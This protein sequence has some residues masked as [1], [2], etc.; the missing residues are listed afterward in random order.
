M[1][2][3]FK[4]LQDLFAANLN[5]V[6]N[7]EDNPDAVLGQAIG[8]LQES[9]AA[10]RDAVID[11][12]TSEKQLHR[13]LETQRRQAQRWQERASRALNSENEILARE[14]LARKRDFDAIVQALAQSH[15][16]AQQTTAR[17]KSRLAALEQKLTETREAQHQLR[18][19]PRADAG[20]SAGDG[21]EFLG[22]MGARLAK[23]SANLKGGNSAADEDLARNFQSIEEEAR[24]ESELA[25][26]KRNL[27][28]D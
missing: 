5:E 4:R 8:E 3:L 10:S 27:G 11:A 26:L 19:E 12:L 25:D 23:L 13:E 15:Q 16:L 7:R 28:K 20:D 2:R 14:A 6:L 9:L 18:A 21:Q 17:L 24:V 1:A 22:R